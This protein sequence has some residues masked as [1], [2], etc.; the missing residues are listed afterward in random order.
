MKQDLIPPPNAVIPTERRN[1]VKTAE[2]FLLLT[3]DSSFQSE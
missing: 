1:R 2:Y 3:P